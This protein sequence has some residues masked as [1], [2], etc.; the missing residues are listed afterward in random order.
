MD[1]LKLGALIREA[2]DGDIN[3][4]EK[5]F[6]DMKDNI[7]S[8]VFMYVHN[9]QLAED[10]LQDTILEI[11][12]SAKNFKL[13]DNP[14]AWIL[15]IARNEA[16]SYM[17]KTSK[18]ELVD[19]DISNTNRSYDEIE[20]MSINKLDVLTM[21]SVLTD[22]QR[23]VVILHIFSGLKHKEI[24]KILNIPI[25]TVCWRYNESLKKLRNIGRN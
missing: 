7:Y 11:Y 9:R 20:N 22:E 16:V 12:K 19:N 25:G 23:E 8:F 1:N 5:I 15:T 2:A 14:K 10:V 17:R 4:L 6:Y 21:L 24:S 18:E 3:V 13:L